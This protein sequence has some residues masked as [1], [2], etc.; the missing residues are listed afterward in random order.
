ML[1]FTEGEKMVHYPID[2]ETKKPY[3]MSKGEKKV[4]P[5]EK[6]KKKKK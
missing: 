3:G 4:E 5:E 2:A 1:R 6:P